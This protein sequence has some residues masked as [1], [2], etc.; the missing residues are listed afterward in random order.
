MHGNNAI[1]SLPIDLPM[2]AAHDIIQETP[3]REV[4]TISMSKEYGREGLGVVQ[5]E[6]RRD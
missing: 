5:G 6:G 3:V 4:G 2:V 1:S